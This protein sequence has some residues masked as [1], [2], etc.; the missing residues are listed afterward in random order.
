VIDVSKEIEDFLRRM[1]DE[2]PRTQEVPGRMLRRAAG[3]R[4]TTVVAGALVM[5]LVGYGGFTGVRALNRPS[6][7]QPSAPEPCTW[8][9]VASP[10]AEEVNVSTRLLA[11]SVLTNGE[12]WAV[13]DMYEAGEGGTQRAIA[14]RWQPELGEWEVTD[15]PPLGSQSSLTDVA[16]GGAPDD[17]WAVG[18]D[19]NSSVILHWDGAGWASVPVPDPGA[20]FHHLTGIAAVASDDVWA[21]GDSATG[22]SGAP[23]AIHW[24]GE[25]WSIIST[26]SP[27]PQPLEGEPFAGLEDVVALGPSD[28][29]A[30]GNKENL[31]P[32]GISNTL[33]LH[34]DGHTWA[35]VPS[36]DSDSEEGPFDYL[37]GAAANEEGVWAVGI[38]ASEA[39]YYGGGDRA[40][41]LRGSGED[42]RLS[43]LPPLPDD[44]R[45]VS[46]AVAGDSAWA[47]G[48]SGVA[49]SFHSL[50]LRWDGQTWSVETAGQAESG[51]LT[52]VAVDPAGGAWAVGTTNEGMSLILRC[53]G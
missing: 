37:F 8:E 18:F 24:D 15:L 31:A 32:A 10:N 20:P 49:N 26:P 44:N 48:S 25:R 53:D 5:A 21:V 28:V 34:W 41:V 9:T 16:A 38:A 17:V 40:L 19:G 1:A 3:Q 29:W 2:A 14:M 52:D 35:V 43:P 51:A 50:I 46:V 6:P 33:V 36:P 7:V 39:G 23:L 13:G 47:V 27:E 45:L 22:H 30:V 11:V 4:L 42:W 12:V